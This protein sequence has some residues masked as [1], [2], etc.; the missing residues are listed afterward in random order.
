MS[1]SDVTYESVEG[2]EGNDLPYTLIII[3]PCL[4]LRPAKDKAEPFA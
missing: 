1:C 3:V 4:P 2:L